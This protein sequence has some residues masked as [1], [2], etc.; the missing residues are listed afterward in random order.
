MPNTSLWRRLCRVLACAAPALA[1]LLATPAFAQEDPP[2]RVGRV[3]EVQG[4]VSWFDHEEGRWAEAERNHPLTTGDRLSTAG[5]ARAELRIGSTVLRLGANTEMELLRLDDERVSIQLHSGTLALRLRSRDAAEET[6]LRTSEARLLPQRA[7]HY[8]FDRIDDTTQAGSW[9]GELRVDGAPELL[10]G[11]GQRLAL[12]RDRGQQLSNWTTLPDDSFAAWVARD[13][14]RDERSASNRYVSPEM[15]GAE[16]LDRAGRWSSHPEFGAIWFPLDVRSGWAPYSVGRWAWVRPWGWTWIDEA[17]WG[18]APF[19]YGRWVSWQGQWGWVPGAYVARPV[20]A[21][22]LVGWVGGGGVSVSV[23]IGSPPTAWVP[24][25]PREV[26]RPYYRTTPVYV[27]R[28]NPAPPYRWHH[29]PVQVPTGPVMYGNQHAP[30]GVMPWR[31]DDG[32]RSPGNGPDRG[33]GPDRTPQ[34]LPA[35]G[36]PAPPTGGLGGML[37]RQVQALRPEGNSAPVPAAQPVPVPPPRRGRDTPPAPPQPAP[38]QAAPVP[39]AQPV[40]APPARPVTMEPQRPHERERAREGE[41]Q[42]QR[43]PEGRLGQ[44]ERGERER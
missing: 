40:A 36:R 32:P 16:D 24:L 41:D 43:R 20:Y 34:Q 10:I 35:D 7:G 39:A 18:F 19:H 4:G 31:H 25:A 33:P 29:P 17:R 1:L 14:Q 9:R 13:D 26:Y 23:R 6:E 12:I 38:V 5:G 22:A 44:R 3:A 2:G 21:P 27:E 8:R 42:R 11:S 15:T 37:H 30:G 28:I